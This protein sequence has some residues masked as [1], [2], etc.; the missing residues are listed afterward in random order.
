MHLRFIPSIIGGFF[1]RI[2]SS[3]I[4]ESVDREAVREFVGTSDQEA[5][6]SGVCDLCTESICTGG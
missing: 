3:S 6:G 4:R 5:A 1:C 2:I